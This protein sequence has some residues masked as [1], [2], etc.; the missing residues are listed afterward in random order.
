M[1]EYYQKIA[2]EVKNDDLKWVVKVQTELDCTK[3]KHRPNDKH[4][5]ELVTWLIQG[6]YTIDSIFIK[7]FT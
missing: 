5:I 1:N 3:G 6:H 2:L 4:K 7:V